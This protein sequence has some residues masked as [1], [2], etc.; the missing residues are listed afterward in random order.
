MAH[1]LARLQRLPIPRLTDR[2]TFPQLDPG[3]PGP[4][5]LRRPPLGDDVSLPDRHRTQPLVY[6][7]RALPAPEV[8]DGA[9]VGRL[10]ETPRGG[11]CRHVCLPDRTYSTPRRAPLAT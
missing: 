11:R 5:A 9:T 1:G 3:R 7:R 6:P 2:Q 10:Y 4:Q 8:A